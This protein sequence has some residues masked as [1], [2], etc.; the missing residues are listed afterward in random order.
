MFGRQ[1]IF[2]LTYSGLTAFLAASAAAPS[3]P[4]LVILRFF[5]GIFG[6]SPL[7]NSGGVIADMFDTK[8]RGMATAIFAA[9]PFLGPTMGPIAGGFLGDA[10]GWRWV[11]GLLAAVCGL[12]LIL[13][14]LVVP[15]T[16]APVLLRRRADKL[17]KLTGKVYI[18]K[19]EANKTRKSIGQEL[20]KSLWRPWILLFQEPIVFI[21]SLYMAIV[22]G[23]LYMMFGAFPIVYQ[24]QRGWSAGVGGLPFIGVALGMFVSIGYCIWDNARFAR[25]VAE[26]GNATPEDRLPPSIIGSVLLPVGLFWFAWTNGVNVHWIVPVVASAFF[27]AGLVLV[28]LSLTNY[29]IDSCKFRCADSHHLSSRPRLLFSIRDRADKT[30]CRRPVYS[31]CTRC[32]FCDKIAIRRCVS[33]VHW[34]HV[35]QL[36]YSLGIVHSGFLGT[37]LCPLSISLLQIRR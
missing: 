26:K 23:T 25:I 34:L 28:F 8:E 24:E 1:K 11:C 21:T 3:M 37:R 9:A 19:M 35:H 32:K 17:S 29:L 27:G 15:E 20:Q 2:I 13:V 5:G 14:G 12:M 18:S 33:S 36:G 4:A 16:Y 31:V 22:Y 30:S 6:S 10:A 7:T